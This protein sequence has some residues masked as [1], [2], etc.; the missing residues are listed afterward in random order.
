MERATQACTTMPQLAEVVCSML[1]SE[2]PFAFACF[3]TTDPGTGIINW[4][5]KSHPLPIGDEEFAAAEYGP[6]D[7]NQFAELFLRPEPFGVLSHDTHGDAASCRRFREFLVPRFGFSDELRVGLRSRGVAWGALALYR[8]AGEAPFEQ[9]DG[10]EVVAVGEIVALAIQ[11]V[12]FLVEGREQSTAR[13]PAVLI[14]GGSD[15]LEDLTPAA[16]DEV[17]ELGGWD[18]G[19][20]PA[21]V[22]A[23]AAKARSEG[24]HIESRARGVSGRWLT[25]RAAPLGIPQQA[26]RVVVTIDTAPAADLSQL[27]FAA[28]GLTTRE[29]DVAALVLRGAATAAIAA[30][31]HL[32]PHTVQDHLKVIFAKLGVNSRRE[33][34]ARFVLA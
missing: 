28:R 5:W 25:L 27:A 32:S 6:P 23:V 3:A 31:L 11:R 7:V 30:A 18:V 22:L 24:T 26:Q 34:V 13:G 15:A 8:G 19:S 21:S 1:A 2:V 17:D 10:R 33:L 16:R 12:L 20:P 4:A 14:L 29:Q 9:A